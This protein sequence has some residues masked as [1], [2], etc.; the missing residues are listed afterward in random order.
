MLV[1]IIHGV[2]F[3]DNRSVEGVI[4][5]GQLGI[6]TVFSIFLCMYWWKKYQYIRFLFLSGLLVIVLIFTSSRRSFIALLVFLILFFSFSSNDIRKK[7]S[8]VFG[9][10]ILFFLIVNFCLQIDFLYQYVGYRLESFIEFIFYGKEGDASTQGRARLIE[11]GLHLFYLS[12]VYGNGS[13]TFEALFSMTQGSW[14]TSADN[15]YVELLADTG[16][17]GF[18]LYY[19]PLIVFIFHQLCGLAKAPL[20]I[21]FAL[22]GVISLASVDFA[23]VWFFSKCGMLIILFCYLIAKNPIKLQK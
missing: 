15:N 13:G 22:S 7:I 18:L 11:Y 20:E 9:M 23:T 5:P 21:T 1:I 4:S 2:T 19:I 17:I 6:T 14:Q 3:Q 10:G 12:P 8:V 16:I